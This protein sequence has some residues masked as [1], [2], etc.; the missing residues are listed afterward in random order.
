MLVADVAE[1]GGD[2]VEERF[3]ADEA[4]V[5]QHV[6]AVGEMLAGA[7]ADFEMERAVVAEQP[8][9]GDLAVRRHCDLRQQRVDQF[10]LALAQLVPARPAVKPVEGQRVAGLV[11]R[12]WRRA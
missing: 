1:R 2:A 7:E 6:G 10:L 12:S 3:G 9:R 5:G 11:A 8:L 4:V